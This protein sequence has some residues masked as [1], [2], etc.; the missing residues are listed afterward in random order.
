M[1]D[2]FSDSLGICRGFGYH[3]IHDDLLRGKRRRFPI[4]MTSLYV[5]RFDNEQLSSESELGL[6]RN[7]QKNFELQ[8]ILVGN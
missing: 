2:I 8:N 5:I 1:F 6:R 3:G 4:Q 7:Q